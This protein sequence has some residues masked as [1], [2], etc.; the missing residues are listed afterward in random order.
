MAAVLKTLGRFVGDPEVEEERDD[1]WQRSPL[2][3]VDEITTPLMVIQGAN[4]PRVTK[5]ESDQIVA[6]LKDRGIDVEYIVADDEGHGFVKP[7]NRMRAYR[8]IELFLAEHLG[9]RKED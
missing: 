1:M 2:R 8:A 7:E 9:G 6:A 5:Q 4:D 3:L